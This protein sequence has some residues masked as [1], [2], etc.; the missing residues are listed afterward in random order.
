MSKPIRLYDTVLPEPRQ[1]A[2]PNTLGFVLTPVVLAPPLH[3]SS[4]VEMEILS[5]ETPA[6]DLAETQMGFTDLSLTVKRA[7]PNAVMEDIVQD[8]GNLQI[9]GAHDANLLKDLYGKHPRLMGPIGLGTFAHS[10]AIIS[11]PKIAW[12]DIDVH[13]M[14]TNERVPD[15]FGYSLYTF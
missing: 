12:G 1:K 13:A 15:L 11:K 7:N 14:F 2:E 4:T 8:L 3:Q 6:D 10:G 5:W 9:G